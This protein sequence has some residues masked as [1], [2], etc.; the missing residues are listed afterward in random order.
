MTT[1]TK[2]RIQPRSRGWTGT[3]NSCVVIQCHHFTGLRR[4]RA[5]SALTNCARIAFAPSLTNSWGRGLLGQSEMPPPTTQML[6]SMSPMTRSKFVMKMTGKMTS[7]SPHIGKGRGSS[8]SAG[9][10]SQR[11]ND[12]EHVHAWIASVVEAVWP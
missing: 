2:T 1:R 11:L 9:D 4:S 6:L 8:Q 3:K 5:D 12:Q 7:P 10:R